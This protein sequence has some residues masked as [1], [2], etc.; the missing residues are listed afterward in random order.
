MNRWLKD[1][2]GEISE[3]ERAALTPQQLKVFDRLPD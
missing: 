2:P 1:D 3:R